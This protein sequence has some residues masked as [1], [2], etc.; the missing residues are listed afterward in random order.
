M[1]RFA[2]FAMLLSLGLFSVGCEKPKVETTVTPPAETEGEKPAEGAASTET[3][4]AEETV[5]EE[6]V[7][8]ETTPEATTTPEAAP[9][10][11]KPAEEAAP[12]E[13]APA[14]EKPAE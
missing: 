7:V 9:A 4:A 1:K 12:A 13:A 5:V 11:E 2:M 14:E 3:P 10:E 8:E 6:T